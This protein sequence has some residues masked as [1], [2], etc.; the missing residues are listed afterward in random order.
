MNCQESII[1]C[2]E[3]ALLRW[4][5]PYV[6]HAVPE[7]LDVTTGHHS[8]EIALL[9]DPAYGTRRTNV[10]VGPCPSWWQAHPHMLPKP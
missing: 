5:R 8:M 6:T 7:S 4:Q 3:K 1:A 9:I 10:H 2:V